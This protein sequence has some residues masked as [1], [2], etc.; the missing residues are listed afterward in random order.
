MFEGSHQS[1]VNGCILTTPSSGGKTRPAFLKPA[2]IAFRMGEAPFT[3]GGIFSLV[4]VDA[5]PKWP[6][7]YGELMGYFI[8]QRSSVA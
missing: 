6:G 7:D 4:S 1:E 8:T 5:A 2:L 3:F